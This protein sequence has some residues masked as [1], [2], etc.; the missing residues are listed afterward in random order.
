M[1]SGQGGMVMFIPCK[2]R[3]C[4]LLWEQE[5]LGTLRKSWGAAKLPDGSSACLIFF[6]S[7]NEEEILPIEVSDTPQPSCHRPLTAFLLNTFTEVDAGGEKKK[8][9]LK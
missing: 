7:E 4:S 6:S 5:H 8:G 2:P 9:L 1:G 3:V